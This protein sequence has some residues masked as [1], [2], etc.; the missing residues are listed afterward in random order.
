MSVLLRSVAACGRLKTL[1]ASGLPSTLGI[2]GNQEL[3]LGHSISQCTLASVDRHRGGLASVM[4]SLG[5]DVVPSLPYTARLACTSSSYI[6]LKGSGSVDR[7]LG[8]DWGDGRGGDETWLT[9]PSSTIWVL[10]FPASKQLIYG[11]PAAAGAAPGHEWAEIWDKK[12][13]LTQT[14]TPKARAG[15]SL[16]GCAMAPGAGATM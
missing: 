5:S 10:C 7:A 15:D 8:E 14:N 13:N 16:P 9:F 2:V 11:V 4:R 1:I 6:I 12:Q 3:I